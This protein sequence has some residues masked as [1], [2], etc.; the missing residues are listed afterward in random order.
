MVMSLLEF[1]SLLH[2]NLPEISK[3]KINKIIQSPIN[4]LTENRLI[5]RKHNIKKIE[6]LMKTWWKMYESGIIRDQVSFPYA[7]K[8]NRIR[9]NII[10]IK[11]NF[12]QLFFVKPHISSSLKFKIKYFMF[13]I[14]IK[15]ILFYFYKIKN[16]ENYSK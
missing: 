16:Y 14:V 12:I 4:W 9:P 1:R 3:K 7:C 6:K 11:F 13:L 8:E 5:L 10:K 2:I 15:K